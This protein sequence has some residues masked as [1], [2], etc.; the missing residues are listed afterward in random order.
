MGKTVEPPLYAPLSNV[1]FTK[2]TISVAVNLAPGES[3][4]ELSHKEINVLWDEKKKLIVYTLPVIPAKET[5]TEKKE[6]EV[7]FLTIDKVKHIVSDQGKRLDSD[8]VGFMVHVQPPESPSTIEA[9]SESSSTEEDDGGRGT[10]VIWMNG[11][12]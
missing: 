9:K 6:N 4:G 1:N 2:N 3:L 7:H 8:I 10:G 5:L 12:P 11:L